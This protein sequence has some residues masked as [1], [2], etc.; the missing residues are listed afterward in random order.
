M[1]NANAGK[2]FYLVN[3]EWEL[4]FSVK[5]IFLTI[6]IMLQEGFETGWLVNFPE[7][8]AD[9]DR[10]ILLISVENFGMIGVETILQTIFKR[11]LIFYNH[12]WKI[13]FNQLIFIITLL[14][15]V[16]IWCVFI[17]D[18][19]MINA[20]MMLIWIPYHKLQTAKMVLYS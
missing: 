15:F 6:E 17:P 9:L 19:S 12:L 5:A 14:Y 4:A 8:L 18:L 20:R 2:S 16:Y 7:T 10:Q 1:L 11:F 13:F 3:T